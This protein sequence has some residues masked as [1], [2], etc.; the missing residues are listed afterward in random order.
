MPGPRP[1]PTVL[2]LLRGDR[3]SERFRNDRPKIND[4][5]CVPPGV[6][7]TPDEQAMWA[8]LLE[9]VYQ[10]GIHATADGAI[11]TKICR[12]WARV[13]QADAKCEKLGCVM[14][15]PKGKPELQPFVRLSRDLWQQLGVALTEAGA[16][17]G[18][19]AKVAGPRVTSAPNDAASWDSIN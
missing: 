15:G 14:R 5:P 12:L 18:G 2:R 10:P 11:F 9:H 6:I 4:V 7:L 1:Q 19:R 17:P 13:N 3:H 8:W 16:T